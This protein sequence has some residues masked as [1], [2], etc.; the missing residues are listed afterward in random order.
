MH[1]LTDTPDPL[2]NILEACRQAGNPDRVFE[3]TS[4]SKISFPGAGIAMLASSENNV[5][6]LKKQI[7]V[8]TIGPDKLNQLRH[9]RFF[10][11]QAGI[12]NHMRQHAAIIEP[13]FDLVLE[14]L[15][16]KLGDKNIRISPS[17]PPLSEL[18]QAMELLT[19]CIELVSAEQELAKRGL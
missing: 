9:V 17:F 8:Q 2:L 6:W 12:E 5:N 14:I 3:F 18:Q 16:S 10:K 13:K 15:E 7:N 4:T 11:G 1:H 19:L